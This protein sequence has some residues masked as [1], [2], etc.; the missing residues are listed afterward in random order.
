M[1]SW[2]SWTAPSPAWTVPAVVSDTGPAIREAVAH[3]VGGGAQRL[4]FLSGP[5]QTTTGVERL[6]EFTAAAAE[7]G[8]ETV[9]EHG[10]FQEESGRAGMR[11][12]LEDRRGRRAHRRLPDDA[13]RRAG[14]AS[15]PGSPRRPICPSSA[16][17]TSPPSPCCNRRCR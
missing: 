10:D 13:R 5:S 9:I 15:K 4:G 2:S 12:L 16:S 3:L 6:A 7:A 14:S 11:A 1:P 17:T 8:V